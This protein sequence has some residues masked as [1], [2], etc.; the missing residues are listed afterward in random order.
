MTALA[1]LICTPSRARRAE[2]RKSHTRKEHPGRQQ[3]MGG[4]WRLD[5]AAIIGLLRKS[6]MDGC[7]PPRLGQG[8]VI[9][10]MLAQMFC[11]GL[12]AAVLLATPPA[13]WVWLLPAAF[14]CSGLCSA[15]FAIS[16][17][18]YMS[19][20]HGQTIGQATAAMQAAQ[21]MMVLLA[22]LAGAFVL[23]RHGGA[24]LFAAAA[25]LGTSWALVHLT[26][27]VVVR[28]LAATTVQL[29]TAPPPPL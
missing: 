9:A 22:P 7:Q 3:R 6:S 19:R 13:Q 23:D 4:V 5:P 14:F 29:S 18:V 16:L 17:N 15:T 21:Q 8:E 1:W 10:P 27:R 28:R 20:Q 26:A 2:L 11:F 25:L 12:F 24:A